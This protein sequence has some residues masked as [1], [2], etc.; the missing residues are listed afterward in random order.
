[1]MESGEDRYRRDTASLLRSAKI[2][3]IFVQWEMRPD[4]VLIRSVC[5]QDSAQVRFAELDEMVE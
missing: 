5:L 2:R 3:S 4:F 1:M